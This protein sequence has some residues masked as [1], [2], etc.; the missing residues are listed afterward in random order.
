MHFYTGKLADSLHGIDR[1]VRR[2]EEALLLFLLVL[3]NFDADFVILKLHVSTFLDGVSTIEAEAVR[4][5]M[6]WILRLVFKL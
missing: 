4:V 3:R 6:F 2:F 5:Y 1:V